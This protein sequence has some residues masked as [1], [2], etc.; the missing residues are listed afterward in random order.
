M[1]LNLHFY[2]CSM[3]YTGRINVKDSATLFC[4]MLAGVFSVGVTFE[5]LTSDR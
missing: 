5:G 2:C 1:N 4:G 3:Y